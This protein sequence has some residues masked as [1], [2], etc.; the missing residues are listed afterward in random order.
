MKKGIN[1]GILVG[2]VC[3]CTFGMFGIFA[4]ASHNGNQVAK[5]TFIPTNSISHNIYL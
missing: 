3:A 5:D 1:K 2:I 4:N